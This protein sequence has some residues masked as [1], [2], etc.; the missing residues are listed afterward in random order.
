MSNGRDWSAEIEI[1]AGQLTGHYVFPDVAEQVGRLLRRRLAGGAYRDLADE[2]ALEGVVTRDMQS[3]NGD[4]HLSIQHSEQ[5]IP[6]EQDLVVD[7]GRLRAEQAMLT[8][9]GFARIERLP[10][11]VGLLDIRKFYEPS[12]AGA[13]AAATAAM[14]LIAT[15]DALLMDLRRNGGGE[16]E[17]VALV[18]GFLFDERTHLV[19]LYFPAADTTLQY[20]TAPFV[21][22]PVFGGSKPVYV[23]TSARTVSGGEGMS[24]Q[25]QQ[26]KRATLVGETTMGA[27][28]FHYP[29]RVSA[30]LMS[31]VPSGYPVDPVS[32]G[33]WEGTGV[34]PDI[35]VPA[36]RALDTAYQLA[37]E[38]VLGLGEHG[39]R[40]RIAADARQALAGLSASAVTVSA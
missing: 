15:A 27:A 32:G 23:L 18:A 21:P 2:A 30:H 14:Q 10:G 12:V 29:Y 37:L 16:P 19:D 11:N 40:R 26:C 33:H 31:T 13:G 17:M 22:G 36:E 1:L 35:P 5:E 20:W 7:T 6:R 8:G 24:Y 39:A 38:H 25:L 4:R 34:Q 9:H 3:V 28:N